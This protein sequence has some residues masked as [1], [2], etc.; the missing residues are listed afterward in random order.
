[1]KNKYLL[2]LHIFVFY[3]LS[4]N[5]YSQVL[6]IDRE[7]VENEI[8]KK[9]IS[10]A[11]LSLSSDKNKLNLLDIASKIEIANFLKNNYMFIG[12]LNY[13][14]TMNGNEVI[15]NEGYAQIRFRDN[16]KRKISNE[17]FLQYQ[18]NGTL[19]MEYRKLIG[20]NVRFKILEKSDIDLYTG[21]G[22]L[23]V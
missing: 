4:S 23:K 7:G 22:V 17:S 3:L 20:S 18:W 2:L 9:W 16:D 12:M 5:I 8:K 15:Q 1:M 10:S 6:N 19:G 11:D 13:N 14:I 21:T